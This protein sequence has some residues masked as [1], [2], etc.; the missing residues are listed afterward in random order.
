M[1]PKKPERFPNSRPSTP[2]S[3]EQISTPYYDDDNTYELVGVETDSNY[4]TQSDVSQ[5]RVT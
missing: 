4:N 3:L 1:A 5:N 2:G